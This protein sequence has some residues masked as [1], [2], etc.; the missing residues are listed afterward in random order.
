MIYVTCV[1]VPCKQPK[2][3]Y[4]LRFQDALLTKEGAMVWPRHLRKRSFIRE[5]AANKRTTLSKAIY[6]RAILFKGV[7]KHCECSEKTVFALFS[8]GTLSL[9]A[10][11]W[12]L[13]SLRLPLHPL[14]ATAATVRLLFPAF[15][16]ATALYPAYTWD[17][18]DGQKFHFFAVFCRNKNTTTNWR[19]CPSLRRLR[20]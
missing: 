2:Q 1:Y 20:K 5:R 10:P 4:Y 13:L 6:L 11:S 19:S 8:R 16:K 7:Q 18:E 12:W 15:L 9:D 3:N 17:V 14:A